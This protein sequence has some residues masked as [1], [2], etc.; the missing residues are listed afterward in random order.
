MV[1]FANRARSARGSGWFCLV[2]LRPIVGYVEFL[3]QIKAAFNA[4]KHDSAV[5]L[6]SNLSAVQES[7]QSQ[8]FPFRAATA[9]SSCTHLLPIYHNGSAKSFKVISSTYSGPLRFTS[10]A[11]LPCRKRKLTDKTL[12]NAILQHPR[13]AADSKMYQDLLEMERKLDWTMTRKKVEVQDALVK[14]PTVH[15]G[16][17]YIVSD[18]TI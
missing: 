16:L 8:L 11:C 12:P 2:A 13:F 14:T 9:L 18:W 17:R 7:Y 5:P 1:S 10:G 4:T 3:V 6:A 15:I